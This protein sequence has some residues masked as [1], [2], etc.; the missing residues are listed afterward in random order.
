MVITYRSN[1][2]TLFL[3]LFASANPDLRFLVTPVGCGL[4][5]WNYD[6]IAPLFRE[7]SKLPN[8]WLPKEFWN[9]LDK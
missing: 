2:F 8:V 6:E 3:F 5:F 4:G 7:A 9:E 1:Y